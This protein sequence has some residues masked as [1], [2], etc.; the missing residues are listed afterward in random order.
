MSA[1]PTLSVTLES[2]GL[3]IV[4]DVHGKA[5]R[6][7]CSR[8]GHPRQDRWQERILVDSDSEHVPWLPLRV[9]E[10]IAGDSN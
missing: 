5:R 8:A 2:S 4:S 10:G 7:L 3:D 1:I 9:C 6:H